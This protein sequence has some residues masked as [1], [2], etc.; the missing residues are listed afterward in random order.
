MEPVWPGHPVGFC[1]LTHPPHQFAAYYDA[2]RVMTVAGRRLDSKDWQTVKL[3]ENVVWDSHNS[4]TMA[5]DSE[6]CIHLSGNMHVDPLVYFRTITPFDITSFERSEMVGEREEKCTYP[7]FI[8][9]PGSELIF[10]YRD[11]KSGEGDQIFNV[12]T[13]AEKRWRRLLD[14]PLTSGDG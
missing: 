8:S 12:Y 6:G 2:D 4:V 10:T 13:T 14:T 11:G 5:I 9:G 7:K 1:L 3:P